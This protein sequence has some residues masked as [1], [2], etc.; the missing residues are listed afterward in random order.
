M[1]IW[2]DLLLTDSWSLAMF[3]LVQATADKYPEIRLD[4]DTVKDKVYHPAVR[5][6]FWCRHMARRTR[7]DPDGID[8]GWLMLAADPANPRVTYG[9]VDRLGDRFVAWAQGNGLDQA[10]PDWI[11]LQRLDRWSQVRDGEPAKGGGDPFVAVSD[12]VWLGEELKKEVAKRKE[13]AKNED[14]DTSS[15]FYP[16]EVKRAVQNARKREAHGLPALQVINPAATLKDQ[17]YKALAA[18]K[19][20]LTVCRR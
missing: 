13:D 7:L 8:L 20:A 19:A 16:L 1:Q 6:R 10:I 4:A 15:G 14:D 5:Q 18:A 9:F 2:I 17:R 3:K 12:A 11:V